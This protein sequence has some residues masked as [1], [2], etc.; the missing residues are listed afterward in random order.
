MSKIL[1]DAKS[2]NLYVWMVNSITGHKISIHAGHVTFFL[3]LSFFPFLMFL[4]KI[5]SYTGAVNADA[6]IQALHN[7]DTVGSNFIAKW[8]ET[9]DSASGGVVFLVSFIAL[10]WSGSKGIYGLATAL[11]DIYATTK[12]RSF[13][14]R[15]IFS[16]IYFLMFALVMPGILAL[17]AFGSFI[18]KYIRSVFPVLNDLGFLMTVFRYAVTIIVFSLFFAVL[19]RFIPSTPA[20]SLAEKRERILYNKGKKFKDRKKKPKNRTYLKEL[21]GA[22]VTS[23]LW[24]VFT[25]LYGI[26]MKFEISSNALY[27]SMTSLFLYLLWLYICMNVVFVGALFNNFRYRTG[28]TKLIYIITDIPVLIK[29]LYKGII[30]T[31]TERK[32]EIKEVDTEVKI[33]EKI[34]ETEEVYIEEE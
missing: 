33:K 30:R 1:K 23:V 18:V 4:M 15:R 24:I 22:C 21:P 16:L 7:Y 19:Y 9:V 31:V 3:L 2:D 8:I 34:E 29:C 5:L 27:G 17:I 25:A 11:D 20:E 12:K 6:A 26:Y 28:R 14:L 13:V 10:V 32:K